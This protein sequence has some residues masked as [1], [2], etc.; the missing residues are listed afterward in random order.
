MIKKDTFI[1][2]KVRMASGM[3]DPASTCVKQ[4]LAE[5]TDIAEE[6]VKVRKLVGSLPSDAQ[7]LP[8]SLEHITAKGWVEFHFVTPSDEPQDVKQRYAARVNVLYDEHQRRKF[9]W[10]LKHSQL[11]EFR[12]YLKLS[13]KY[14][15][16][17]D[18]LKVYLQHVD[19]E[20]KQIVQSENT[21]SHQ[22][23]A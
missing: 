14:Q 18:M 1:E 4:L 20:G 7:A 9:M 22:K 19:E 17:E 21:G 23:S 6:I 16:T 8:A 3:V 5:M 10:E 12:K 11:Q 13:E 2:I 15:L